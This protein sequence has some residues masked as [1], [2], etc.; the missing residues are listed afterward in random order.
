M[1]LFWRMGGFDRAKI[2]H[3]LKIF[4]LLLQYKKD[5]FIYAF[6]EGEDAKCLLHFAAG[7]NAANTK[8][9]NRNP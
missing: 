7:Q 1:K 5:F 9:S 6:P 3:L 2:K 8:K 4:W